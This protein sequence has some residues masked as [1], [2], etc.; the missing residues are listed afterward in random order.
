[1]ATNL[2]QKYKQTIR[3]SPRSTEVPTQGTVS[4]AKTMYKDP[5]AKIGMRGPND[6]FNFLSSALNA[7][8]FFD[9]FEH[10]ANKTYGGGR[11]DLKIIKLK[12]LHP[13][14]HKCAICADFIGRVVVY[15]SLVAAAAVLVGGTIY[16]TIIK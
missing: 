13:R 2:L 8:F 1:M 7:T 15:I 11:M 5:V 9:Y 3:K 10:V 4:D 14:F 12:T 16:K 6:G